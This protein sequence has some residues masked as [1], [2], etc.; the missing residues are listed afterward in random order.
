MGP[1][2]ASSFSSRCL[3][4]PALERYQPLYAAHAELLRRA[5]TVGRG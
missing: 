5:L 1:T 2:W 4:L 3:T